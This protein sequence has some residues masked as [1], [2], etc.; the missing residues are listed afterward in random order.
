MEAVTDG[1]GRPVPEAL[2][3]AFR[4]VNDGF[5]AVR[6][7]VIA[8]RTAWN[9]MQADLEAHPWIRR[10]PDFTIIEEEMGKL[11]ILVQ[12]LTSYAPYAPVCLLRGNGRIADYCG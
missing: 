12:D 6:N 2:E 3:P 9:Q 11:Q 5:D 10:S 7:K 1:L 4:L 8:A